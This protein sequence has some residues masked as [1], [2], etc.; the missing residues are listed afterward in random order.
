VVLLLVMPL[1]SA[2]TLGLGLA[3]TLTVLV[4]VAVV[5]VL[6]SGSRTVCRCFG[7]SSRE[8]GIEH[9]VRN[10]LLLLLALTGLV[11]NPRVGRAV[12]TGLIPGML[13]GLFMGLIIAG[14][15]DLAH[16]VLPGAPTTPPAR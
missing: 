6:R 1:R 8:I 10:A 13:A 15:D 4:S 12:G 3:A 11:S 7:R 9:L 5:R 14:F 16:L 2:V